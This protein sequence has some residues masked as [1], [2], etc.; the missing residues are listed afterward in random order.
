MS[1]KDKRY[2]NV[3]DRAP[4]AASAVPRPG[5]TCLGE[6]RAAPVTDATRPVKS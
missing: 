6:S 1:G 5:S 3:D 4:P 2:A